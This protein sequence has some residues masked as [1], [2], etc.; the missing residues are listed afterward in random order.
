[1]L[2]LRKVAVTGGLSSGKSTACRFLK[3][4]G[5]YIVNA[6]EIVHQ[7]LS[8]KTPLGQQVINL[9]GEDIVLKDQIDRS[10]IA[11]RV[12]ND[13]PLLQSLEALLHPAV[14]SEIDKRYQ[15]VEKQGTATLFVAEIPLLFEIAGE[16]FFD[17]TIVVTA[18]PKLCQQRFLANSG[19]ESGEYEKRMRHQMA[20]DEKAKRADYV[21]ENS[22]G[23][24]SMH[25]SIIHLYNQL[26]S[27]GKKPNP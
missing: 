6:D 21:I 4:L 20:P 11:K 3:E 1:M 16:R 23:M 14:M 27:I 10:R 8:P 15:Q 9:L 22:G 2:K 5:A 25:R 26:V 7:L 24:E 19:Y 18:D 12:F 13:K 17:F